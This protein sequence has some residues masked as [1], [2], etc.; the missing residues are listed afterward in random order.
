M[1]MP[2]GIDGQGRYSVQMGFAM[3]W[4]GILGWPNAG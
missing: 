1:Q 3:C 4:D 2:Y